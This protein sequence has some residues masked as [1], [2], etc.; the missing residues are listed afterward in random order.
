MR[1]RIDYEF[2]GLFRPPCSNMRYQMSRIKVLMSAALL[3]LLFSTVAHAQFKPFPEPL[4][5]QPK[6]GDYDDSH[7]WRDAAWWWE[8]RADWV[9]AQHP[10][11]W[12]DF[13][14]ARVWH[15]ADWWWGAGLAEEALAESAALALRSQ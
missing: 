3:M 13:D 2:A 9:R 6:W 10:D 5:P 14:E 15:P 8:N 11:W 1:R 12:G 7:T 4:P